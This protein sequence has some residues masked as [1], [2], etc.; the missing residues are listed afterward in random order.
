MYHFSFEFTAPAQPGVSDTAMSERIRAF[1]AIKPPQRVIAQI[2]DLQQRMAAA[3]SGVRWV[4]TEG[5]HLTLKFLGDVEAARVENVGAALAEA[6]AVIEPFSLAVKGVGV[7]ASIKRPRVI[8]AGTVDPD[9]RLSALQQAVESRLAPLGFAEER[10]PFR[11]HLTLGRVKTR[12]DSTALMD[13]L[14]RERGFEIDPFPVGQATLFQ[15]RL[16]PAGAEY[17]A[18]RQAPLGVRPD[19]VNA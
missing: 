9:H 3:V 15:S 2:T 14:N 10:R 11:G 19:S 8:W 13:I 17:T 16:K 7:F 18:L 4:R 5:I 1:I 12:L 6:A